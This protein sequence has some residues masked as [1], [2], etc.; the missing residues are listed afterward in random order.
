[1]QTKNVLSF[2]ISALKQVFCNSLRVW[3]KLPTFSEKIRINDLFKQVHN[4]VKHGSIEQFKVLEN[5]KHRLR[6]NPRTSKVD[7]TLL[8]EVKY[9]LTEEVK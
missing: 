4:K 9:P 6:L 7:Q 1:M 8:T 5:F 3:K 2:L